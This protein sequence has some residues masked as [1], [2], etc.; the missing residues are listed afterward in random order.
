M[1]D[2]DFDGFTPE[3]IEFIQWAAR[4]L[5][6]AMNLVRMASKEQ[7]SVLGKMVMFASMAAASAYAQSNDCGGDLRLAITRVVGSIPEGP[8]TDKNGA[9]IL[10][11]EFPVETNVGGTVLPA[12]LT[13][14]MGDHVIKMTGAIL[15][16]VK[17]VASGSPYPEE[18]TKSLSVAA[19]ISA[20][21]NIA[22][23]HGKLGIVQ[24]AVEM[25]SRNEQMQGIFAGNDKPAV[26][27]KS[28]NLRRV[29][30]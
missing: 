17:H 1:S 6:S 12:G 13:P 15:G 9:A 26:D 11:V 5:A 8:T 7:P 18:L 21:L 22:A 29:R 4:H 27:P 3:Q 2:S 20:T 28:T 25:F 16:L 24:Q 19:V 10:R 23:S 14:D 30:P